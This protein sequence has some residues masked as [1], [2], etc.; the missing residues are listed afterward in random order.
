M[1]RWLVID[2]LMYQLDPRPG[3]GGSE[4]ALKKA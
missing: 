3:V 1:K 2:N 4:T